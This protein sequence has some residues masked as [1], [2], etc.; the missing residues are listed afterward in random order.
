VNG[1]GATVFHKLLKYRILENQPP[2]NYKK[3]P[4]FVWHKALH[5]LKIKVLDPAAS[6]IPGTN[7]R[8]ILSGRKKHLALKGEVINTH[9]NHEAKRTYFPVYRLFFIWILIMVCIRRKS[10]NNWV[11]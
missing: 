5:P 11:V 2:K 7:A 3:I 9:I 6:Q 4:S 10:P 8:S 1:T